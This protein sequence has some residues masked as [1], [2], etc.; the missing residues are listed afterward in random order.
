MVEAVS[1]PHNIYSAIKSLPHD[2]LWLA[3]AVTGIVILA[4]LGLRNPHLVRVGLRNVPRRWGR[5]ALIVFG[6]MFS[7]MFVASSLMVDDTITLAVKSVA[8]FNLGRIDEDVVGFSNG[9]DLYSSSYGP[10]VKN[11]LNGDSHVAGV[12]P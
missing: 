3:G 1:L 2:R 12:A 8:V 9:L 5:T 10:V 7:T 11:A 4:A 6:L